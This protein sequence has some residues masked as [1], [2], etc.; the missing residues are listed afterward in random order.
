MN[1]SPKRKEEEEKNN[2]KFVVF[3]LFQE[4]G[5]Q[6]SQNKSHT[7]APFSEI[8]KHAQHQQDQDRPTDSDGTHNFIEFREHLSDLVFTFVVV[9]SLEIVMLLIFFFLLSVHSLVRS[10]VFIAAFFSLF[11]RPLLCVC[12]R[13]P[14]FI[15]EY[16]A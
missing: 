16:S 2:E 12:F 1:I 3:F 4:N 10:L 14:I 13:W 11:L 9:F 5:S 8:E 6:F 15:F 7:L